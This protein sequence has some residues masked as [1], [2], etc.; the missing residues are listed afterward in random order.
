MSILEPLRRQLEAW[1]LDWLSGL[2][3][4]HYRRHHVHGPVDRLHW[5]KAVRAETVNAIFN[6]RSGHIYIGAETV[7]GHGVMFLTGRHLF[8]NGRLKAPRDEQVPDAGSDIRIGDGCWVASGAIVLGD[9]DLGAHSIVCA[10]A[11]V[12]RSFPPHSVVG[13]VP[14]RVIGDTRTMDSSNGSRDDR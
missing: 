1:V 6:T 9:V 11:V 7:I 2:G 10:G 8:E 13:G 14:A 12:T 5:E 3:F 4:M